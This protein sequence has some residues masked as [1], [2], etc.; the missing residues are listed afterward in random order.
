MLLMSSSVKFAT[1]FLMFINFFT[2]NSIF[3]IRLFTGLVSRAPKELE[4]LIA[5]EPSLLISTLPS[6]SPFCSKLFWFNCSMS[7]KTSNS[8]FLVEGEDD[9]IGVH[10]SMK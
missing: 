3:L 7:F 5:T 2:H 6:K 4:S 8:S 10:N 1:N 9:G